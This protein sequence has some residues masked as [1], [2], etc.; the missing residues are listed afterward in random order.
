MRRRLRRQAYHWVLPSNGFDSISPRM[1]SLGQGQGFE[2]FSML[3]QVHDAMIGV[4]IMTGHRIVVAGKR[5][6]RFPD[7]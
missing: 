4:S 5:T 3:L 2:D 1:S 6:G 7:G